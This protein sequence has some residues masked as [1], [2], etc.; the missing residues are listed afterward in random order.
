[1]QPLRRL[2]LAVTEITLTL[3]VY[4][5]SFGRSA[6]LIRSVRTRA[7]NW[8][9]LGF[10]GAVRVWMMVAERLENLLRADQMANAMMVR[11]FTSPMSISALAP[12]ASQKDWIALASL[13]VFWELL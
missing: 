3:S 9:K 1:M 8:K 2:K 6:N 5:S 11:G 13:V 7:I 10:K 12:V 4:P